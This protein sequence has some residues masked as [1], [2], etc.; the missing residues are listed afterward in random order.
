VPA[1]CCRLAVPA[2]ATEPWPAPLHLAPR[3][4]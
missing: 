3:L 4:R 1:P 2:P